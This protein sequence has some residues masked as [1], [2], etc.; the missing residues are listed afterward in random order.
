MLKVPQ[1]RRVPKALKDHRQQ[2]HKVLK[3]Q[4]DLSHLDPKVLKEP[5]VVLGFLVLKV[6]K[7]HLALKVDK[8][9]KG[10]KVLQ[11]L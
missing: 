6:P 11:D 2:V 4:Q 7:E 9:L 10:L 3:V 8:E 5:K 1:V